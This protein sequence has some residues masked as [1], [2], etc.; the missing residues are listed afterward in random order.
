[1][2]E[3]NKIL[4]LQLT[5][6]SVCDERKTLGMQWLVKEEKMKYIL[7]LRTIENDGYLISYYDRHNNHNC[8][9]F[10]CRFWAV[11]IHSVPKTSFSLGT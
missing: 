3:N 8:M 6:S 7:F 2:A 10:K 11:E 4:L 1:M 9:N 5:N